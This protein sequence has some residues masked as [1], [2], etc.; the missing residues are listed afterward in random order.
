MDRKQWKQ[1]REGTLCEVRVKRPSPGLAPRVSS[2][3][4]RNSAEDAGEGRG[5]TC[6]PVWRVAPSGKRACQEET[7]EV[8]SGSHA[9]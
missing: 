3:S 2:V 5:R 8:V 6:A 4:G 1:D 9:P 7:L